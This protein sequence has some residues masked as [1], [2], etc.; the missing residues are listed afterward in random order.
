[1]ATAEQQ[2]K[3]VVEEEAILAYA[4]GPIRKKSTLSPSQNL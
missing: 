3:T 2:K 4:K 1:M